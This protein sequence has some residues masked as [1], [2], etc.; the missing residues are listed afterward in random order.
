MLL[1]VWDFSIRSAIFRPVENRIQFS[2]RLFNNN[3]MNEITLRR[4]DGPYV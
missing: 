1:E 3:E 4:D 2:A